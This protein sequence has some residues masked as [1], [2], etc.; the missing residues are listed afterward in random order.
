MF[1]CV[2]F[3]KAG[4]QSLSMCLSMGIEIVA[5]FITTKQPSG[6]HQGLQQYFRNIQPQ[7]PRVDTWI[8]DSVLASS[9][10]V[11]MFEPWSNLI[12][13]YTLSIR[14]LSTK[15]VALR[16]QSKEGLAWNR[17]QRHGYRLNI[18]SVSRRYETFSKH[19]DIIQS[20]HRHNLIYEQ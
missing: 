13:Y 19:I 12:K 3:F 15:Q 6:S 4:I 2:F 5:P 9:A 14:C 10:V 20:G 17:V 16:R 8:I 1:F 11:H 18:V 7:C